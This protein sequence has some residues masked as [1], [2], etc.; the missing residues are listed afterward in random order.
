MCLGDVPEPAVQSVVGARRVLVIPVGGDKRDLRVGV[1]GPHLTR[2]PVARARRGPGVDAVFFKEFLVL[3]RVAHVK[4]VA[5]V[6][7]DERLGVT[8]V[9]VPVHVGKAV[10][11]ARLSRARVHVDVHRQVVAQARGRG[12]GARGAD[13][14][15]HVGVLAEELERGGSVR[16]HT[17]H[18][19]VLVHQH[20]L[21]LLDHGV[22][23]LE[24]F[25]EGRVLEHE[26]DCALQHVPALLLREVLVEAAE[27]GLDGGVV[28]D[29]RWN[30]LLRIGQ[31]DDKHEVELEVFIGLAERR[32]EVGE[33]HAGPARGGEGEGRVR[34]LKLARHELVEH[35][36]RERAVFDGAARV[37]ALELGVDTVLDLDRR[38]VAHVPEP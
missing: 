35:E 24:R 18:V 8:E 34:R 33:A 9:V 10:D 17:A 6:V 19:V 5:S 37:R 30:R 27:E 3:H 12:A 1:L 4:V 20:P 32:M 36:S 29:L 15:G 26:V 2:Q 28:D 23:L 38:R 21:V 16:V 7:P 25:D 31:R 22:G 13:H 11:G 14:V